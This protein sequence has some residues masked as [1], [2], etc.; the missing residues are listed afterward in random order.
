MSKNFLSTTENMDDGA[1]SNE[2]TVSVVVGGVPILN[3][4]VFHLE[5][6]AGLE[7]EAGRVASWSD[8]SGSN[9]TLTSAGDPQLV[10]APEL[11]DVQVVDFDGVED[12]L[13]IHGSEYEL[14]SWVTWSDTSPS[15]GLRKRI[16]QG[17]SGSGG[18]AASRQRPS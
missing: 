3:G 14:G 10:V 16:T 5:S 18:S 1:V 15:G 7:L 17:A 13:E 9:F 4:L 12:K 11:G 2:A 6:D 8:I